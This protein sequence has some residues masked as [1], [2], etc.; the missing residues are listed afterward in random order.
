M[1]KYT[2]YKITNTPT[3][4]A[5]IGASIDP[6]S[7]M[8][9]H[10]HANPHFFEG[11][12]TFEELETELTRRQAERAEVR[13]I[14]AHE[15]LSPGGFNK[16]HG[17]FKGYRHEAETIQKISDR[18]NRVRKKKAPNSPE[19]RARQ[20]QTL[21]E[22]Y[23]NEPHP[24][25][26]RPVTAEARAKQSA[27]MRGRPSKQKGAVRTDE[28]RDKMKAGWAKRRA[29]GLVSKPRRPPTPEQIAKQKASLAATLARKKAA[30]DSSH[31]P[32][33]PPLP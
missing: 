33:S 19:A 3:G 27:A 30:K 31:V 11:G 7:R 14:L 15:T 26:G 18:Y 21:R 12:Y 23:K 5:Y 25:K 28:T 8:F 16:R 24:A 4:K 10:R 2:V 29:E 17:G 9:A 20:A 22:K 1:R 6:V 32:S 13:C